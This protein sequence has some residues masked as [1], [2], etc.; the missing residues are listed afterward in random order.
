MAAAEHKAESPAFRVRGPRHLCAD[1]TATRLALARA[2]P[3]G[4]SGKAPPRR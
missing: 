3:S 2:L 4:Q 1:H